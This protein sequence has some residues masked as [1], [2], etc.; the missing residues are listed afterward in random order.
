MTSTFT[1][2]KKN[3]Q[4]FDEAAIS[5]CWFSAIKDHLYSE[6]KDEGVIL[7]L[8]N[9]KYYGLNEVG[10]SIWQIIQSPVTV[11]EI[12][13]AILE[14][15]EIDEISCREEVITFLKQMIK[16]ELVEIQNE[17]DT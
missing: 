17:K 4:Q 13:T 11:S 12:Q 3:V 14:E 16:E 9:G 7:S 1:K 6:L 8:K 5:L 2:M 15:Y 10:R